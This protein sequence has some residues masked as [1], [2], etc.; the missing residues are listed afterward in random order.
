MKG[1]SFILLKEV[2]IAYNERKVSLHAN[3][4]VKTQDVE[5]G[6]IVTKMIE[7]TVGRVIL[8]MNMFLKKWV[9][10]TKFY[11]KNHFVILLA[12]LSMCVVL[13]IQRTFWM[14]LKAQ[15]PNGIQRLSVI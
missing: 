8:K 10:S 14:I 4:S 2:I 13:Q 9:I 11:Q 1:L 6:V 5:N 7:T 3:I 12:K 15:L